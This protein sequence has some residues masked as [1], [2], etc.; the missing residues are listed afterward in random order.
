MKVHTYEKA[1]MA[2]GAIVLVACAAALVYATF[3]MGIHLPGAHARIDPQALAT[4]APF[5]QPGVTQVAPGRYQAVVVGRAW[6]FQ[7]AELRVPVGSEVTF[8]ATSADVLHGLNIEGTRLNMM[9]I[10]GQVSRNTYTFKQPGEYLIICHEYCGLGHH[11]MYGTIIVEP[12]ADA[13]G[14]AVAP[15]TPSPDT[16]THAERS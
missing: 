1:F 10:P 8:L 9:L 12:A 3:G 14:A 16:H 15:E 4:T 11:L 13:P 7:P 2:A 6:S 5:D